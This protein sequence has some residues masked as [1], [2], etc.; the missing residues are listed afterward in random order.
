MRRAGISIESIVR[1]SVY[2]DQ[3][4]YGK[5]KRLPGKPVGIISVEPIDKDKY[6]PL[7]LTFT[8]SRYRND[9]KYVLMQS[10]CED[11]L[12]GYAKSL[13]DSCFKGW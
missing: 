11:R 5:T 13:F 6:N 3:I 7:V 8:V 9:F 2:H 12:S 10:K 4:R 1:M